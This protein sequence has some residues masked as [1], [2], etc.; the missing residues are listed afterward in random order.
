MKDIWQ[1]YEKKLDK[2]WQLNL[3]LLRETNIGKTEKALDKYS[4]QQTI[5]AII[6]IGVLIWLGGLLTELKDKP[7]IFVPVLAALGLTAVALI[8]NI[9]QLVLSKRIDYVRPVIEIQKNL[10]ALRLVK[11]R[12]N[13]FIFISSYPYVLLLTI[14]FFRIDVLAAWQEAQTYIWIQIVILL[15][16]YPLTQLI[17]RFYDKGEFRDKF[18]IKMRSDSALTEDTVSPEI[19]KALAAL[20][21]IREFESDNY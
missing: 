1:D 13:R 2:Q 21:E 7:L 19:N 9:Y 15:F 16:W 11:L 17:L 5:A 3:R 4:W 10:Q 18:W 14:A 8:A 6:Q 20:E 12:Y